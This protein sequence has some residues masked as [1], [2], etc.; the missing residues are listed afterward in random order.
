MKIL[1]T[2]ADGQ[3]G[4]ELARALPALGEL[5]ATDRSGLDLGDPD[6]IRRIL[7]EAKP[8]LI[9][10]AGGYTAV[11]KAE[12]EPDLAMRVNAAG[13]GVLG[14]EAKRLGALLVHYSSD[15]V[16]DGQKRSPYT[17]SGDTG[18]GSTYGAPL[19][20]SKT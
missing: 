15:Y 8:Q 7:R 19:V 16:F 6:A 9:V 12:S 18:S 20:P 5:I 2:G 4:W 13:P 17:P 3:V 10:N 1:L 11:D 14:E